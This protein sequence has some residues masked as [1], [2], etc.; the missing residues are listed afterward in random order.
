MAHTHVTKLSKTV[1]FGDVRKTR[2][3]PR[4]AWL[5]GDL[6]PSSPKVVAFLGCRGVDSAELVGRGVL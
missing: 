1:P 3:V 5:E 6:V 4:I 2:N